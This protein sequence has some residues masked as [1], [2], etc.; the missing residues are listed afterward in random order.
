MLILRIKRNRCFKKI[1][2]LFRNLQTNINFL[3]CPLSS[4]AVINYCDILTPLMFINP[5]TW[6]QNKQLTIKQQLSSFVCP[7]TYKPKF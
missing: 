4:N 6:L 1:H 5:G 3:R 7:S 2:A